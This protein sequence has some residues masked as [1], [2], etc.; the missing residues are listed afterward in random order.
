VTAQVAVAPIS[1]LTI[2]EPSIVAP[3]SSFHRTGPLVAL[4]TVL[5]INAAW[6]GL[7]GYGVFQLG[8]MVF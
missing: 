8:K 4:T 7:L 5:L 3:V 6:I 1:L 2:A